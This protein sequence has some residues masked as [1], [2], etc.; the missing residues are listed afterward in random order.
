MATSIPSTCVWLLFSGVN[1]IHSCL[2]FINY[3][4]YSHKPF[5]FFFFFFV[6]GSRAYSTL[7]TIQNPP[8]FSSF[9]CYSNAR[10]ISECSV[11]S[12]VTTTLVGPSCSTNLA[13]G[14]ECSCENK[15]TLWQ[16]FTLSNSYIKYF[17]QCHVLMEMFVLPAVMAL[18]MGELKC[19]AQ[20]HG[21]QFVV[22]VSGTILML[23]SFADN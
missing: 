20:V 14:L 8:L 12:G 16:F 3:N 19:V 1:S 5:F 17:M 21:E 11:P 15:T 10:S 9:N 7:H 13:L 4:F 22:T 23:V 18:L 6:I 2:W